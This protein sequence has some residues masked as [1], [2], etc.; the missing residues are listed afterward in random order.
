MLRT[1]AAFAHNSF[2]FNGHL[3]ADG[4]PL[5]TGVAT[6]VSI[7]ERQINTAYRDVRD[8]YHLTQ[9]G[10]L[11]RVHK[12]FTTLQIG[13]RIFSPNRTAK[14][15]LS[16][17]ERAL[18]AAF[19]PALCLRDSPTTLGAYAFTFREKTTDTTNYPSGFMD[20]QWFM[21]PLDR[22]RL[23]E[24]IGDIGVIRYALS[25]IAAD[26]RMYEQTEQALALSSGTPTGNVINLG[27]VPAALKATIVMSGAGAAN[28]TI[29][30]SGVSFIL[31]LSGLTAGT[32]IVNFETCAPYGIGRSI[33]RS[34]VSVF[35]RKTSSAATWL[36][37]PVGTTSFTISNLTGITSCTL[38]WY[39]SRA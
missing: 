29:T 32:V 19:D 12:N 13:G 17:R 37:A 18:M 22:P 5:K 36:D 2:A 33:T 14:S 21:R 26:P 1:P 8:P 24:T 3:N 20:L 4:T 38:N 10:Q 27:T 16:D 23:I 31:D 15:V 28:F 6:A 7:D 11:G 35:S 9:G 39:H 34:G 25:L 30:R